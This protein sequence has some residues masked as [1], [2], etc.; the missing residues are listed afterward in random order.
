V[1]D[2]KPLNADRPR[3]L[4]LT[5]LSVFCMFGAAMASLTCIALLTPG[6]FLE[7]LWSLNPRAR[8]EFTKIGPW[9]I[10]LML[11]VAGFCVA[12]A[13]GLWTRARWGYRLA[14]AGLSLNLVADLAGAIV[15]HDPVRLVG[16][17]IAGAVLAYLLSS[18]VRG[19]FDLSRER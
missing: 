9:G 4:G 12:A 14:V 5:L 11:V 10:V 8:D 15:L 18:G 16:I 7:P 19:Q 13:R 1:T 2:A 17:P 6:G 3:S